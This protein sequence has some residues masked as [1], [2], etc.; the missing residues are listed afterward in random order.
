MSFEL[1]CTFDFPNK[2]NSKGEKEKTALEQIYQHVKEYGLTKR[3]IKL[4][5]KNPDYVS[6]D[7]F[8]SF[9]LINNKK[10]DNK[11]FK[12][13]AEY[14]LGFGD[15][16]KYSVLTKGKKRVD[17]VTN[18]KD[19]EKDEIICIK[20]YVHKDMFYVFRNPRE[21]KHKYIV[22]CVP[23]K[24]RHKTFK[25][26]L[27]KGY[28]YTMS[29]LSQINNL[30][31]NEF[32]TCGGCKGWFYKM[33]KLN[34]IKVQTK[35]NVSMQPRNLIM[36]PKPENHETI[37]EDDD[38]DVEKSK[39]NFP[40]QRGEKSAHQT[41]S[42]R[43]SPVKVKK[44]ETVQED[45]DDFDEIEDEEDTR[46]MKNPMEEKKHLTKKKTKTRTR[47]RPVP[48]KRRKTKESPQKPKTVFKKKTFPS[49]RGRPKKT[50][51]PKSKKKGRYED[52]GLD[53]DNSSEEEDEEL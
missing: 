53:I 36:E 37:D 18:I 52:G 32:S 19:I 50:E 28:L 12:I 26:V 22:V 45:E 35:E 29:H 11:F 25:K 7:L 23:I 3:T 49:K 33:R 5:E 24:K 30:C 1:C 20:M 41:K 47:T 39:Q 42:R 31:V 46:D 8:R 34:T 2:F 43:K 21:S 51:K 15:V 17:F 40:P 48:R 27:W 4:Q 16:P 6:I 14:D 10:V 13:G 44:R 9:K 38:E